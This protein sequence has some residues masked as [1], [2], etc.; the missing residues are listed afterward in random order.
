MQK[1]R[2]GQKK[3]LKKSV[4]N[5]HKLPIKSERPGQNGQMYKVVQNVPDMSIIRMTMAK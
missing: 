4:L 2:G 1:N 3:Q 5:M